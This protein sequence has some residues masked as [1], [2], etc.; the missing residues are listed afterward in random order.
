MEASQER[1]LGYCLEEAVSSL[2]ATLEDYQGQYVEL[3]K[4]E[5]QVAILTHRLGLSVS[6]QTFISLSCALLGRAGR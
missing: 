5:Q 1:P 2:K 6:C 4:L 3:R